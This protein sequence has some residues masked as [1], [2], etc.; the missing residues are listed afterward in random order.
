MDL[1]ELAALN[2]LIG[3]FL[4]PLIAVINQPQWPRW[5]RSLATVGVCAVVGTITAAAGGDLLGL[6]WPAAVLACASAAI[7]SYHAWWK[8]S[9]ITVAVERATSPK[10]DRPE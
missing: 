4:P 5:G 2:G 3:P 6:S 7:T 10:L 8:R 9:D 1:G